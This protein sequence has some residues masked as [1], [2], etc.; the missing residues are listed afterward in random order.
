MVF[1]DGQ[2]VVDLLES[3]ARVELPDIL[4]LQ[5]LQGIRVHLVLRVRLELRE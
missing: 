4:E 1:R 5:V 3:L 2:G